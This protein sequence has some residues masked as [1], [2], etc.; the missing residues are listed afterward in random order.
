M[1][2]HMIERQAG[3]K[4]LFELCRNF[5]AQLRFGFRAEEILHSDGDRIVGNIFIAIEE[6][7]KLRVCHGRANGRSHDREAGR[8]KKTFRTVPQFRRAIALW[9]SSRR[10]T[11]FRRRPDCR[12]HFYSDRGIVEIARVSRQSKWPFT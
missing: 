6:L 11:S 10:N 5:V 8:W 1:A 3:G 9:I 2:V 12:K 7:W 4:K